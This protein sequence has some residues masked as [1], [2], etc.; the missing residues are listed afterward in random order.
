MFQEVKIS[1]LIALSVRRNGIVVAVVVA[2]PV[3]ERRKSKLGK[4]ASQ[5]QTNNTRISEQIE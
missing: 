3:G 2:D 4:K 5:S 1:T